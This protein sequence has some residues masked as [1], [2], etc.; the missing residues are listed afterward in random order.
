MYRRGDMEQTGVTLH[1]LAQLGSCQ[2]CLGQHKE[3]WAAVAGLQGRKWEA[4]QC[5]AEQ[6]QLSQVKHSW[7]TLCRSW[8][9]SSALEKFAHQCPCARGF[10]GVWHEDSVTFP[11]STGRISSTETVKHAESADGSWSRACLHQSGKI[12]IYADLSTQIGSHVGCTTQVSA[13]CLEVGTLCG[14]G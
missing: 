14:H 2:P 11:G 13:T 1:G 8:E 5:R 7:E 12:A 10:P 4:P 9:A 6:I 3:G